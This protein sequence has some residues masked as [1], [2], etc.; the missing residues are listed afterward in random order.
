MVASQKTE[1]AFSWAYEAMK[2]LDKVSVI[3]G[4]LD[5]GS[6]SEPFS[7]LEDMK[8]DELTE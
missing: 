4:T 3:D 6:R 8:A 5:H 7:A 2:W 1:Q